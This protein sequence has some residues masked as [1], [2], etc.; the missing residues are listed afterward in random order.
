M[1]LAVRSHKIGETVEITFVRDGKEQT[2]EVT[3]GDDAELQKQQQE[4]LRQ[5]Q[6]QQ[7]QQW[8]YSPYGGN[9]YGYRD[10]YND[11]IS[12]QDIL[13]YLFNDRGGSYVT[14]E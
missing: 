12:Y 13:E 9:G 11:D 7:Q 14:N 3:F 1:I 4:K 8:Q 5:Q 6:E 2:A 10:Y